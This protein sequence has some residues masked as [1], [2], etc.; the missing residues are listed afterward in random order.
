[1]FQAIITECRDLIEGRLP[2]KR[3]KIKDLDERPEIS[4]ADNSMPK[5]GAEG[6][7]PYGSTIGSTNAA[8]SSGNSRFQR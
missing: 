6:T 5:R 4:V 8:G 7:R 3:R 1:M 2:R